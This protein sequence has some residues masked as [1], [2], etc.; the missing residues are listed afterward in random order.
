MRIAF[1]ATKIENNTD[2]GSNRVDYSDDAFFSV[3]SY[4][5]SLKFSC[6]H[7]KNIQGIRKYFETRTCEEMSSNGVDGRSLV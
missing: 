5:F 4:F 3:I 6:N 1:L 7:Q 2:K